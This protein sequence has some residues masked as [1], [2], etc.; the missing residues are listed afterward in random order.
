MA[1]ICASDIEIIGD[2]EV[3]TRMF[4]LVCSEERD[5]AKDPSP[6]LTEEEQRARLGLAFDFNKVVPLPEEFTKTDVSEDDSDYRIGKAL[7]CSYNWGTKSNAS[8]AFTYFI[9][10][11]EIEVVPGFSLSDY[12]NTAC[13][14]ITYQT[15]WGIAT[16]VIVALSKQY[17]ELTFKYACKGD[18]LEGWGYEV[19]KA[20]NLI[21]EEHI[22]EG[23]DDDEDDED[24][25]DEDW[26]DSYV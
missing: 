7:W 10:P 15:L 8:C 3:I 2:K 26:D 6:N 12:V 21:A 13:A 22:E 11:T 16:P 23:W 24:W 25:D 14:K 18:D 20:G 4:E 19:W 9:D 1:N 5:W 17:P